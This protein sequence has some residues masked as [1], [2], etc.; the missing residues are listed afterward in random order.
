MIG[1]QRRNLSGKSALAALIFCQE[2][3]TAHHQHEDP[4][5][6]SWLA[7]LGKWL[8]ELLPS[9]MNWPAEEPD[10]NSSAMP[11]DEASISCLFYLIEQIRCTASHNSIIQSWCL[12]LQITC[13]NELQGHKAALLF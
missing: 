10:L 5:Q 2:R 3:A 6:Q 7:L 4:G 12:V 11:I 8:P 9:R 1:A 13:S